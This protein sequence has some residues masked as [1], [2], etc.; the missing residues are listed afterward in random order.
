MRRGS[1]HLMQLCRVQ[2]AQLRLCALDVIT[3]ASRSKNNLLF[4]L[5]HQLAEMCNSWDGRGL[6]DR[7]GDPPEGARRVQV[8]QLSWQWPSTTSPASLV[9]PTM[10]RTFFSHSPCN[11][12]RV[13]QVKLGRKTCKSVHSSACKSGCYGCAA[14]CAVENGLGIQSKG[15]AA[16]AALKQSRAAA[17][18]CARFV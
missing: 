8:A 16:R 13:T 2:V 12:V 11:P 3:Q 9:K 15:L 17:R 18:C 14:T 1:P 5:G 10:Y 4:R 6:A 7:R